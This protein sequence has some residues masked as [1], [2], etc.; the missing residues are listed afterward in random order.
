MGVQGFRRQGFEFEGLGYG[1]LGRVSS[2]R[3]WGIGFKVTGLRL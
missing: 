1:D 2:L 3:V